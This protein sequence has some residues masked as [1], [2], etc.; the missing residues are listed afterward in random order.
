MMG[1]A[2][3][4]FES[5]FAHWIALEEVYPV[6]LEAVASEVVNNKLTNLNT[7]V[8]ELEEDTRTRLAHAVINEFETKDVREVDKGFVFRVVG[9]GCCDVGLDAINYFICS[10]R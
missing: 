2:T 10:L 5:I 8:S 7:R 3:Y 4:G 9:L 1:P 6:G